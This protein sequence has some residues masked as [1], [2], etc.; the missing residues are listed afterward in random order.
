MAVFGEDET[1]AGRD[2][3]RVLRETGWTDERDYRGLYPVYWHHSKP[4]VS[5][6]LED[7]RGYSRSELLEK[8]KPCFEDGM[9]LLFLAKLRASVTQ[10]SEG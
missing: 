4:G 3:G 9:E 5:L 8:L 7:E 2:V 6:C 10:V 1:V